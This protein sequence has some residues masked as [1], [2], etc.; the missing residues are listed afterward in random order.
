M[1]RSPNAIQPPPSASGNGPVWRFPSRSTSRSR[2][3]AHRSPRSAPALNR[4]E[5]EQTL[6][7]R[8][9]AAAIETELKATVA[10]LLLQSQLALAADLSAPAADRVRIVANLA[11]TLR[12]QLNA[13]IHAFE[14]RVSLL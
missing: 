6:A 1:T 3:C 4:R 12:E 10:G 5:R 2:R 7:R 9:A 8:A 14:G 11:S 13:P